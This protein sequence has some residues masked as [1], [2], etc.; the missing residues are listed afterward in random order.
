MTLAYAPAGVPWVDSLMRR[1]A[2]RNGLTFGAAGADIQALS[3]GSSHSTAGLD[4]RWCADNAA[5]PI[6][7]PSAGKA[8]APGSGGLAALSAPDP[9]CL[10]KWLRR[11]H[12]VLP[13]ALFRDNATLTEYMLARATRRR[14]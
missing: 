9:A 5:M 14:P 12:L 6:D 2:D 3:S 13:C 8:R 4:S 7:C 1:V 11:G 10:G